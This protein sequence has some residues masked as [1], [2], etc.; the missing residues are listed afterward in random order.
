MKVKFSKQVTIYPAWRGNQDLHPAEQVRVELSVLDFNDLVTLMEAFQTKTK[1]GQ[2][3][4][5]KVIGT[6]A[7]DIIPRYATIHNLS[8]DDGVVDAQRIAQYPAYLDL[9]TEI[10]MKL[11][12]VS[13]PSK[14]D[15]KNSPPPPV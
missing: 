2:G 9:T 13:T 5:T 1:D 11:A 3:V 4:D 15:E 7:K 12:E 8:D 14:D 6:M 10:L